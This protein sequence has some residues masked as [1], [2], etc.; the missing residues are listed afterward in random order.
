MADQRENWLVGSASAAAVSGR[1][2]ASQNVGCLCTYDR[3]LF[4]FH[5]TWITIPGQKI[6]KVDKK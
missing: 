1:K 3:D 5:D 4:D 6:T 2:V